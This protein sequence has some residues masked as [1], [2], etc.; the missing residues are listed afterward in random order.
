[1]MPTLS[2]KEDK[3]RAAFQY[4][5][6]FLKEDDKYYFNETSYGDKRNKDIEEKEMKHASE[7]RAGIFGSFRKPKP[8]E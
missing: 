5:D 6:L 7:N 4:A 3:V 2:S 1:M 8:Q